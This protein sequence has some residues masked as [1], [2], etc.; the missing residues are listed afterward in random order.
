MSDV[1]VKIPY[2]LYRELKYTLGVKRVEPFMEML[3]EEIEYTMD[4][5][6][7]TDDKEREEILEETLDEFEDYGELTSAIYDY[8][9]DLRD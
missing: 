2:D 6:D 8:I 7:I 4:S 3:R 1:L 5:M 9:S